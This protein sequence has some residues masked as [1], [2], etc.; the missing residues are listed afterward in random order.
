MD[1]AGE[2]ARELKRK[3]LQPIFV[4][5]L[6]GAD[7]L[8]PKFIR[9]TERDKKHAESE[10]CQGSIGYGSDQKELH[11]V[12]IFRDSMEAFGLVF[13][14]NCDSEFYYVDPSDRDRYIALDEYFSYLKIARV[15]ELKKIAQDLGAKHFRVTYKE[16]QTS[17]SE[18]KGK[19]HGKAAAAEVDAEHSSAEKK[20][21]T[22]ELEADMECN[23]PLVKTTQ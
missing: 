7:F 19:I 3:A 13:Y 22:V 14:P 1:S 15:N 17:F 12:N 20:Y 9:L 10:V 2:K 11:I 18:K 6:N 23:G 16:E 4:D 21:S 5:T 8:M